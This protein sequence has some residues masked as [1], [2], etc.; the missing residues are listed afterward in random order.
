MEG[1]GAGSGEGGRAALGYFLV[2]YALAW[3]LTFG[4]VAILYRR[5]ARIERE[6][7]LLRELVAQK[8]QS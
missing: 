3:A 1:S 4:Y 5:Q 7:E 8:E 6:L 2:A